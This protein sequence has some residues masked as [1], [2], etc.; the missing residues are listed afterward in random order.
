M[1]FVLG[2]MRYAA[3]TLCVYRLPASAFAPSCRQWYWSRTLGSTWHFHRC[4]GCRLWESLGTK[5][6]G[7][8]RIQPHSRW[9]CSVDRRSRFGSRLS[10]CQGRRSLGYARPPVVVVVS[11]PG[12]CD[13][14]VCTGGA[15]GVGG[16]GVGAGPHQSEWQAPAQLRPLACTGSQRKGEAATKSEPDTM[17]SGFD[18]CVP[19]VAPRF[20]IVRW[21]IT[22]RYVAL[23]AWRQ[24]VVKRMPPRVHLGYRHLMSLLSDSQSEANSKR[25]Q[26]WDKRVRPV[27]YGGYESKGQRKHTSSQSTS[28]LSC[29]VK[30]CVLFIDA[31]PARQK[32][33]KP[34]L[35]SFLS[36]HHQDSTE[37]P[38]HDKWYRVWSKHSLY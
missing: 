6:T 22:C 30:W 23:L 37:S 36:L 20:M 25:Q 11:T 38:W 27:G 5:P 7:M 32:A 18:D 8:G 16:A 15:G 12:C 28:D 2:S 35:L 33:A 14:K 24:C 29:P 10:H 26:W 31:S 21:T 4:C 17:P 1:Q 9:R 19:G 13:C 3:P 34:S